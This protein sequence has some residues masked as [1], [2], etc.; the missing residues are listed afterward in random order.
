MQIVR[1]AV[2]TANTSWLLLPLLLLQLILTEKK[3]CSSLYQ[4][5]QQHER[6]TSF[7]ITWRTHASKSSWIKKKRV[8]TDI[9]YI[10]NSFGLWKHL[11][12]QPKSLL[13]LVW[14]PKHAT[15]KAFLLFVSICHEFQSK[16]KID[17][18][19][20]RKTEYITQDGLGHG[21]KSRLMIF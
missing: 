21:T 15:Q 2:S 19:N 8:K 3:N 7:W 4:D 13:S 20:Y 10:K 11:I 1:V 14:L 18:E 12:M 16:L 9:F 5:D 6:V 17:F